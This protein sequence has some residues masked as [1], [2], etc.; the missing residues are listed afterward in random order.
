[1]KYDTQ[2]IDKYLNDELTEP[3]VKTFEEQMQN[4]KDFAYEVKLQQTAI[5]TV[6]YANFMNKVEGVRKEIIR[7]KIKRLLVPIIAILLI[8]LIYLIYNYTIKPNPPEVEQHFAAVLSKINSSDTTLGT[9]NPTTTNTDSIYQLGINYVNQE[10]YT[11]AHQQFDLLIA[12]DKKRPEAA[13]NKAYI[14]WKEGEKD[15]AK[16]QLEKIMDDE[17]ATPNMKEKSEQILENIK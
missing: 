17:D 15:K 13:F 4:D 2:H 11:A 9:D 12:N 10:E 8:S 5:E 16:Q 6:Q 3:E 7:D 14:Y 1:M